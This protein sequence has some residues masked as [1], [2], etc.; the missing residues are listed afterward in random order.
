[1]CDITDCDGCLSVCVQDKLLAKLDD[2]DGDA[3]L[4]QEDEVSIHTLTYVGV[5]L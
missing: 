4:S 2:R 3:T 1:M 5:T